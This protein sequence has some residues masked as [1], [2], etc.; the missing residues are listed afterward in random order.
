M[1][2]L[3]LQERIKELI[4]VSLTCEDIKNNHNMV[5]ETLEDSK[6]AWDILDLSLS[7]DSFLMDML[8]GNI[9]SIMYK[10]MDV[11]NFFNGNN[12][13]KYSGFEFSDMERIIQEDAMDYIT[14]DEV[15]SICIDVT[16][17]FEKKILN[18]YNRLK[19]EDKK[20]ILRKRIS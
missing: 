15:R 13:L 7:I 17:K 1:T 12:I 19:E 18:M 5:K 10:R 8:I 4:W 3:V 20:Y 9:E 6:K 16:F 2:R 14:C 11:T